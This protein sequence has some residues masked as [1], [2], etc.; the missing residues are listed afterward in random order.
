MNRILK[1]ITLLLTI[2]L[3][4]STAQADSGY[5]ASGLWWDPDA[6]GRGYIIERQEDIMF[7]ISF[8]YADDGEPEW[9][10]SQGY[11]VASEESGSLGEFNGTVYHNSD[12]QCIGC[13]YATPLNVE[14]AQGPLTITFNDYRNAVLEW[15]DETIAINKHIFAWTDLVSELSGNWLLTLIEGDSQLS[16]LVSIQDTGAGGFAEVRNS[17]SNELV[18]SVLLIDGDAVLTLEQASEPELPIIQ[19]DSERFYAGYS[20]AGVLQAVAIRLD[21]LPFVVID[22]GSGETVSATEQFTGNVSVSIDDGTIIIQTDGLPNHT[23][24]YWGEGHELYEAPHQG[25]VVNPNRIADQDLTFR[26][27]SQPSIAASPSDTSLGAIGIAVNGVPFYNQYAGINRVTNEWLPLDDEIQSFDSKNGHPQ[28]FGQYHYHFEPLY[29]TIADNSTF[30]GFALDGFPIYGPRNNDDSA[31]ALDEC[32][33]ETHA[34]GEYPEGIYHYHIT[35][36][37]PYILGCFRGT[38]GSVSQ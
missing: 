9:L 2:G 20:T 8:H 11:F 13:D 21:D 30:L 24:P 36:V 29:L 18:G 38:P 5:P 23:S 19:P 15:E 1:F 33:G 26:I 12:G 22:A 37:V 16:Q 25:M 32:N 3:L 7:I 35:Q 27:P 10:T 6:S 17:V 34:T 28:N 31:L 4:T 14:S